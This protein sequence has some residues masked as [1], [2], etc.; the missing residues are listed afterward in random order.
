[1][2]TLAR[3]MSRIK[4]DNNHCEVVVT[5]ELA[6]SRSSSKRHKKNKSNLGVAALV[7]GFQALGVLAIFV[8][9]DEPLKSTEIHGLESRTD[10]EA[11]MQ[12]VAMEITGKDIAVH[13]T[14]LV[15]PNPRNERLGEHILHGTGKETIL[16]STDFCEG[17]DALIDF[18]DSVSSEEY[19]QSISDGVM[20]IFALAHE[21][22]HAEGI[23]D[24]GEAN[25]RGVALYNQA[26]DSLGVTSMLGGVDILPAIQNHSFP[27]EYHS[28]GC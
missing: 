25:C 2:N 15:S 20:G 21:M 18:D 5:D 14:D 24:E 8:F 10:V 7:A 4:P 26:A 28:A 3:D 6:E 13:C 17:I 27:Q 16:I 9:D 22:A 1:M 12:R 23:S 11:N 19:S